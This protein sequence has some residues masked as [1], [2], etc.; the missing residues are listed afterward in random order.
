MKLNIHELE[1]I[2][3]KEQREK[4]ELEKMNIVYGIMLHGL[5]SIGLRKKRRAIVGRKN[6]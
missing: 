1:I 6:T 4:K 3:F 5:T 2:Q